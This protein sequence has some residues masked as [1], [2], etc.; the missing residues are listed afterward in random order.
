MKA[1]LPPNEAARLDTLHRYAI[2]DTLP[3]QEFDDLTRLAAVICGTPIALVSLVD[4][5]RQWFKSRVGTDAAETP[6]E[7]AFCAHAILQPDVLVVPN[8]LEDERFRCNPLVLGE[9]HV[10]FYAGAPL[11]TKEGHALGT[12]CVIDRTPREL[13][14]EQREALRALS[15]LVVTQFELRRSV[16]D[17]SQAILER[18][19]AETELNELFTLSLDML[20]IAGFDG[21]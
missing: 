12:L 6:R 7:V 4:A 5:D 9:P 10:R 20:C 15:R 21:Y 2:L 3:E 13:S 11:L 8:A 17:L 19:R 1:P 18:R 16:S 14:A